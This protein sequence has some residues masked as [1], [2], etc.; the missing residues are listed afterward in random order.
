MWTLFLYVTIEQAS[1][2]RNLTIVEMKVK[3]GLHG[4]RLCFIEEKFKIDAKHFCLPYS[5]FYQNNYGIYCT[6]PYLAAIINL[7]RQTLLKCSS[8][9]RHISFITEYR[10]WQAHLT[11]MP[12]IT[13]GKWFF[14]FRRLS[15]RHI[16]KENNQQAHFTKQHQ[17]RFV[18]RQTQ[19]ANSNYGRR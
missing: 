18:Q 8:S 13:F 9:S 6:I 15:T 3:R 16:Q 7:L 10:L 5:I 2:G 11:Q 1:Q 14:E 17:I 19:D 12:C 4:H